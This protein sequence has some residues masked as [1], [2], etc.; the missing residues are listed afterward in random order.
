MDITLEGFTSDSNE[1]PVTMIIP[2]SEIERAT[3]TLFEKLSKGVSYTP[4]FT[5]KIDDSILI[6]RLLAAATFEVSRSRF[7]AEV[8]NPPI[9]LKNYVILVELERSTT[10]RWSGELHV[11]PPGQVDDVWIDFRAGC[12]RSSR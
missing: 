6:G 7:M 12:F 5:P 8:V 3:R 2:V 1:T 9:P 4:S 11:V 10:G